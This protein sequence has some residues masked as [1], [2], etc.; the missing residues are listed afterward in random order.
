MSPSENTTTISSLNIKVL[1][2][3][4]TPIEQ[5][6]KYLAYLPWFIISLS[7]CFSIAHLKIRYSTPFYKGF[8]NVMVKTSNDNKIGGSRS[9]GGDLIESS[10]FSNRQIN[11]DNEVA[12]LSATPLLRRVVESNHFNYYYFQI[13]SFRTSELANPPFQI[14]CIQLADSMAGF[15]LYLYDL[16]DKG[17][18]L[19]SSAKESTKNM[20]PFEWGREFVVNRNRI[21]IL[22]ASL[23]TVQ[24]EKVY[25]FEY[26]P[27][28]VTANE[29]KYNLQIGPYG[30]RTTIIKLELKG[31][32]PQKISSVLDAIVLEYDQQNI[33]DKNKVL[34]NTIR[35][36]GQR[37]DLVTK[38][39]GEVETD[40]KEFKQSNK[41]VD[42][43]TQSSMAYTQS[44]TLQQEMVQMGVQ[45]QL[46]QIIYQ[47]AKQ[48]QADPQLLPVNLGMSSQGLGSAIDHYNQIVLKKQRDEPML[49]KNSPLLIDLKTQ[50]SQGYATVMRM[51]EEYGRGIEIQKKSL[52]KRMNEVE[53]MVVQAP[54]KEKAMVEIRRQQNVKE[55]LYLYLLQKREESAIASSSTISNY[56]QLDPAITSGAPIEPNEK[57]IYTYAL[58]IGLVIPVSLIFIRDI[59]NDKVLNRL[60]ITQR[61][62]MPI[63]AEISHVEDEKDR[64]VVADKSRDIT[65]EQFRILRTNLFFLLQDRNTIMLTSS[66]SGEGKSFIALN[67]AAVLAISGKQVAVLEF[68]LRK[69]GLIKKLGI[70]KKPIGIS[71]FLARQTDDLSLMYHQLENY[72]T[73][74]VYGSGPLPPNPAEL[75]IGN[76]MT[77]LFTKL[78][79]K[80]DYVVVDTSPVG[81]VSDAFSLMDY[82]DTCLYVVRQRVSLKKQL[83]FAEDLY[84]NHQ[85]KNVGMVFNDIK[86]GGRYGYYGHSYGYGY[87]FK[88][89]YSYNYG[90]GYGMNRRTGYGE[91]FDENTKWKKLL[92]FV[93]K[94]FIGSNKK[95]NSV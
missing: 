76:R 25:K 75:M 46:Y 71:N 11:L 12:L 92:R 73:L 56:T 54:S 19:S 10:M 30:V 41:M 5:V 62:K 7:I 79:E 33:E 44:N 63:I 60:D 80:Y 95:N 3:K 84:L 52:E 66:M 27:A 86:M 58:V 8:T 69:P 9:G 2:E 77:E 93:N 22:P 47:Q 18:T 45:Q 74:H 38:E 82:V 28:A 67:L 49:G 42:L 14:K 43:G 72:S 1:E 88:R 90:Y 68:D 23:G 55:G 26:K 37:L 29:I 50:L 94:P 36:I 15:S 31:T 61:T 16:N 34:V 53:G 40:M 70:K 21:S 13:G 87:G 32:N 4:P 24:F 59:L 57:S 89:G 39:L 17:G 85:L 91:Q 65:A 48:M 20:I 6:L 51:I 83:H 35:F 81:L 64:L 78:K